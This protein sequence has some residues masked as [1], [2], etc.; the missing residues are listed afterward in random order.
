[1][2]FKQ[3]LRK[4]QGNYKGDKR[5]CEGCFKEVPGCVKIF[6][7]VFHVCFNRLFQKGFKGFSRIFHGKGL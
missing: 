2:C 7:S 5:L 4:F 1:M 6:F 3:I